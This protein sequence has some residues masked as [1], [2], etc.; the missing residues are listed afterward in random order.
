MQK[1]SGV[2][3]LAVGIILLLWG[4]NIANS[5]GS[6]VQQ[7]F[8]GSPTNRAMHFYIGGLVLAILGAALIFWKRK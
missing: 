7:I 8:T 5:V 3:C 1:T 4:H 6:Q 2:I